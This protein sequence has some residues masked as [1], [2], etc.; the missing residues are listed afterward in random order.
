MNG[1][2]SSNHGDFYCYGCFY[3]FRTQTTLKNHFEICEYND[4]CSLE[5][6]KEGK[7]V[8]RYKPGSRSLKINSV[9]YAD[10]ECILMPYSGCDKENVTTKKLDK[11]VPCGYSINVVSNHN[12]ETKQTVYRGE[13]A[14]STFCKE[15]REIAQGILNTE[16]KS[17]QPLPKEEQKAYDNA[18]YCHICKKVLGKHKNHK[19][20]RDHDHYTGK[21]RSAAHSIC[22]LRYSMQK[23]DVPVIF[24]NG[25]NYDFNL[26]IE[27]FAKE[28][29]SDIN[30]IPL[31]TNKYMSFS[32]PTKKEV[33]EPKDDD[34]KVQKK[35][36][37]YSLR[38]NDS[39][40]HMA[41][42]LSTLVDNLSEL[43]VCKCGPNDSRD[44]IRKGKELKGK[45]YILIKC[46]TCNFK[47]KVKDNILIKRFPSTF[48]SCKGNLKKFLLLL[49]KGVY[50]YEYMDSMDKFNE[51]ELPSIDKFYS[52]PQKK[53]ISDKDYA[54]AKKV[55]NIFEMKTPGDYH[56][57]Y[58]Q[59]DTAQL[60][61][62]FESFRS[63]CLKGYSL[64][65]AILFQLQV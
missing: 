5:V 16:T 7:N 10:F 45:N 9:I 14:V 24:H 40:K 20:V 65:P 12:K 4:F 41:R 15:L 19:K 34:K 42:G 47:K 38:F 52:K 44:I 22:N 51:T 49:R 46:N 50:P 63:T 37:T 54:H 62:A 59:A 27:E 36:L 58:V 60:S 21:F 17:M 6:P 25:S 30:C 3:S 13:G 48:K 55:W 26:L 23:I 2:S 8:I 64:D 57:L 11:H 32:V 18:R 33:I 28:Y 29:K 43:T 39:A 53:H 56:D 31:N 61:D 1:I 35:V